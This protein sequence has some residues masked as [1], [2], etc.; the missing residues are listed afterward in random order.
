M[1]PALTPPERAPVSDR[2]HPILIGCPCARPG[3]QTA[4]AARPTDVAAAKLVN[5]LLEIPMASSPTA[6]PP[7]RGAPPPPDKSP[8]CP[9][10]PGVAQVADRPGRTAL[11]AI[12]FRPLG[13]S[14]RP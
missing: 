2:L 13:S 8:E 4:G 12:N 1:R 3:V 7:A 14:P 9:R 11:Q 5:R 6:F 10:P